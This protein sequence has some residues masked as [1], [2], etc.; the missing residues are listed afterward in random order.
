MIKSLNGY[1]VTIISGF[2][3]AGITG[4]FGLVKIGIVIAICVLAFLFLNVVI[5]FR[6][7]IRIKIIK[8]NFADLPYSII[9]EALNLGEK[10]NSLEDKIYFKCLL[11]TVRKWKFRNGQ[12]FKCVFWLKSSDRSLEPHKPKKFTA[13][14]NSDNQGLLFSWFRKYEFKPS[15]GMYSHVF[16]RNALD[17]GIS[18]WRY[19]IER[20]FYR[21]FRIVRDTKEVSFE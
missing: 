7:R 20:S 21:L 6:N 18:Y 17:N 19:L 14:T 8:Q 12:S 4:S 13:I 10:T 15:R 2:T 3:I 11:P 5:Y 16:V 9:F 1:L